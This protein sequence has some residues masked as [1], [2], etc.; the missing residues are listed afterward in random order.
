[1]SRSG[2]TASAGIAVYPGDA[3]DVGG[4]LEVAAQELADAKASHELTGHSR[5]RRRARDAASN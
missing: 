5:L 2:V 4:L 1:M 3:Q